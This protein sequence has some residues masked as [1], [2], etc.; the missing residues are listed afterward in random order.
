MYNKDLET[1]VI[2][3]NIDLFFAKEIIG[4][5]WEITTNDFRIKI[6]DGWDTIHFFTY[7]HPEMLADDLN[8]LL[9]LKMNV[10]QSV[11]N[12]ASRLMGR[13]WEDSILDGN[14]QEP[15]WY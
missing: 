9:I 2:N 7:Q 6:V 14:V 10:S 11:V 3:R 8:V 4:G 15:Y 13:I 5:N 1:A 12:E